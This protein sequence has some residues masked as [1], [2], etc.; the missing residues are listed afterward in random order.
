MD[1]NSWLAP[2]AALGGVVLGGGISYI[3]NRQ[4]IKAAEASRRWDLRYDAYADF[5]KHARRYRNAIRR[6]THPESGPS[7]PLNEIHDLGRTADAAGSLVFLVNKSPETQEACGS[8]MKTMGDTSRVLNESGADMTDVPWE[9]LNVDMRNALYRFQAAARA[10]L[11]VDDAP[12]QT[13][14]DAR[15]QTSD[16]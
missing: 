9:K 6:P 14:H 3:L 1:T 12:T 7:V 8:L 2:V 11:G 5:L 10:E 13:S 16:P 15:A 4:Q